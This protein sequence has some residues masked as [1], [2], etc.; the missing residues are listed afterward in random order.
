MFNKKKNFSSPLFLNLLTIFYFIGTIS[1]IF[2]FI[3]FGFLWGWF[4]NMALATLVFFMLILRDDEMSNN[5][6]AIIFLQFCI[7]LL[8]AYKK[9]L[10][11]A[12]ATL[13]FYIPAA[14]ISLITILILAA[15]AAFPF[16]ALYI[17][18]KPLLEIYFGPLPEFISDKASN[19]RDAHTQF[20][21]K[22]P[23]SAKLIE[24]L[25]KDT[26]RLLRGRDISENE[27]LQKLNELKK[28]IEL[29]ISHTY[30]E[31]SDDLTAYI[32]FVCE[33]Y[34]PDWEQ[35]KTFLTQLATDQYPKLQDYK[36]N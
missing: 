26:K 3:N 22:Y 16:I 35:E 25:F 18:F 8:F 5:M 9:N 11:I 36:A 17:A 23:S 30:S 28:S 21:K 14:F 10:Y 34:Y 7:I 24:S 6:T 4:F 33:A 2:I 20:S 12:A 13:L 19:I 1:S 29:E 32:D 31:S 15:I 27:I